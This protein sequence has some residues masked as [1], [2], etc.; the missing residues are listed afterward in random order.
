ML[1]LKKKLENVNF[2]STQGLSLIESIISSA[3]LLFLKIKRDGQKKKLYYGKVDY[4]TG[5]NTL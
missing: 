5:I 2:V 4:L 1:Q 3:S